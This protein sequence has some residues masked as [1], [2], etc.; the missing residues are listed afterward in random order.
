M[1]PFRL[2]AA[3]ASLCVAVA[4]VDA[5][6]LVNPGNG[7][8]PI[9]LNPGER[10]VPGSLRT[11]PSRSYPSYPSSI[12]P[13]STYPSTIYPSTSVPSSSCPNCQ[14]VPSRRPLAYPPYPDQSWTTGP[15]R[16]DYRDGD[17]YYDPSGRIGIYMRRQNEI[18]SGENLLDDV[19]GTYE[20]ENGL[21]RVDELKFDD[22]V[23]DD[24]TS[25]G[26]SPAASKAN[27]L[28]QQMVD[29]STND[30]AAV[31]L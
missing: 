6:T 4:T 25:S 20:Q 11:L 26:L 23:L 18:K 3:I 9:R 5:Q 10:F 1:K 17:F 8:P 19:L 22:R 29:P 7:S 2:I 30:S 24:Q 12:Y 16:P 15:I 27:S 13:S 31:D 28:L 21:Q 14:P